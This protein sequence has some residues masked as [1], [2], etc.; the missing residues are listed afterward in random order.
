MELIHRDDIPLDVLAA[1]EAEMAEKYPGFKIQCA[2]DVPV[3]KLPPQVLAMQ[4]MLDQRS[5][6]SLADGRCFDC[7]AHIPTWPEEGTFP[8]GWQLPEGWVTMRK[9]GINADEPGELMGF[10]CPPCDANDEPIHTLE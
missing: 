2:G 7:G 9:A 8:E 10:I 4:E 5:K 6:C 1:F 3:D